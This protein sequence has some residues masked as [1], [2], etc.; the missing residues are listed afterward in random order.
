[1][2]KERAIAD[3]QRSANREGKAMVVLNLNQFSPLYVVR[4]FDTRYEGDRQLVAV[5]QPQG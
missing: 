3:A 5:V 4:D 2:S 1:M